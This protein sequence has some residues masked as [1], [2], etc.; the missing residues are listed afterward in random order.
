M[1]TNRPDTL[2]PA[3]VRPGRLDRRVE[4]AL[5]D[6]EVMFICCCCFYSFIFVL[7]CRVVHKSSRYTQS[8]CPLNAI[9]D[10]IYC[11]VCVRIVQVNILVL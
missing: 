10:T 3:L 5:P 6:L 2:D 4:F 9:S 8:K 11:H 1:A 7:S